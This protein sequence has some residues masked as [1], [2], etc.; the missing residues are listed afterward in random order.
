ME[1]FIVIGIFIIILIYYNSILTKKN[2]KIEKE[3][4]GFNKIIL[5]QNEKISTLEKDKIENIEKIEILTNEVEKLRLQLNQRL[6]P[7]EEKIFQLENEISNLQLKKAN[8]NNILGL[9]IFI[10]KINII[11]NRLLNNLN[12]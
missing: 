7:S 3:K 6:N 4:E 12:L 1:M 10:F 8:I 2:K 9:I 5:V 11:H